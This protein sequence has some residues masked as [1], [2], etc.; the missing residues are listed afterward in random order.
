MLMT[1]LA[2]DDSVRQWL[3][4]H[5]DSV[6]DSQCAGGQSGVLLLQ[7]AVESDAAPVV[8]LQA[9]RHGDHLLQTLAWFH[10]TSL[11]G[12]QKRHIFKGF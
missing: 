6:D 4:G 1:T 8:I 10:R 11:P 9:G 2:H 5:V 3:R 12:G 7:L